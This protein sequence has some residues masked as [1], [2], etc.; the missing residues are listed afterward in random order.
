MRSYVDQELPALIAEAFPADMARQSIM[1][2]S[3]GGHGAL[4]IGLRHPDRFRAISAFAPI[5]APMSCPWGQK[6]LSGYLG[7]D[8]RQWQEY[9]A[10]AL[11]EHGARV[12]HLLVDQG[13]AD[14][15]LATQLDAGKASGRLRSDRTA[16]AAADAGGL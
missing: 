15:F 3:M 14:G 16:V 11:I 12:P 13:T 1:G 10:C 8:R 9:D 2:H 7:E 4:I 5:V 6:A